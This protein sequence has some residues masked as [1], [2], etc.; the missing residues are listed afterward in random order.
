MANLEQLILELD[1]NLV[2]LYKEK[3]KEICVSL[4][5][6]KEDPDDNPRRKLI[7]EIKDYL[8]VIFCG[9]RKNITKHM[10]LKANKIS[11]REELVNIL[12][13][14]KNQRVC[15]GLS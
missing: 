3:V 12:D 10:N 15:R 1:K 8:E 6:Y 13:T 11:H 14:F 2:D 9:E 5:I 4:D 7:T